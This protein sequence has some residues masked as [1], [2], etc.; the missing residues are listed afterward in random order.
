MND[1]VRV[2]ISI[3]KVVKSY[4]LFRIIINN[5]FSVFL[6]LESQTTFGSMYKT[7]IEG[8]NMFCDFY[9]PSSLTYC[10]RLRVMC[11]EHTKAPL[12]SD[13]EVSC[14]T[15]D[16]FLPLFKYISCYFLTLCLLYQIY[17]KYLLICMIKIFSR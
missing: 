13:V 11:P 1:C 12:V 15:R 3:F 14:I 9:N 10:K 8:N 6:Q 4:F 5:L 2:A 17:W 16:M 7:R